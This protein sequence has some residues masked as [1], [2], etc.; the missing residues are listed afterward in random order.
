[1]WSA[2]PYV[3]LLVDAVT[4]RGHAIHA[5]RLETDAEDARAPGAANALGLLDDDELRQ[6][7]P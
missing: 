2:G 1:M 5:A 6:R 4:Q 7:P 3:P